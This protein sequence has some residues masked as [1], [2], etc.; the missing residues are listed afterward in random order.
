MRRR[1]RLVLSLKIFE[2]QRDAEIAEAN[3][4][5]ATKKARWNQQPKL[6]EVESQ[7]VVALKE[8]EV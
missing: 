6:D 2:N 4:E 1:S 3:A 7:K 8:A 5:L